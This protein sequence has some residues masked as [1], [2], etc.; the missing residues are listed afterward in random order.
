MFLKKKVRREVRIRDNGFGVISI[1]ILL[2]LV[3]NESEKEK[4]EASQRHFLLW[5]TFCVQATGV[6]RRVMK[7]ILT[8]R[9]IGTEPRHLWKPRG[10]FQEG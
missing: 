10:E 9:E 4:R 6:G 3:E 2:K 7:E 1:V 8:N 5:E